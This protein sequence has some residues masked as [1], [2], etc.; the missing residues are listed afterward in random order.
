MFDSTRIPEFADVVAA[1]ERI[2]PYAVETPLLENATLNEK[3]GGRV[4]LKPESLQRTGSF[5]VPGAP[6]IA[7]A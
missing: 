2:A 5:R 4:F 7:S 1:A 3:L 6:A